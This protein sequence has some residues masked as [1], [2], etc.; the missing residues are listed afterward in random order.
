LQCGIGSTEVKWNG[1]RFIQ[2]LSHYGKR[3]I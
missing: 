3:I 1:I 2:P